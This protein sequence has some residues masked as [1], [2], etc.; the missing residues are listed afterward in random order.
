MGTVPP[1][2]SRCPKAETEYLSPNGRYR[3]PSL[4]ETQEN[5]GKGTLSLLYFQLLWNV[6]KIAVYGPLCN[7]AWLQGGAEMPVTAHC[8]MLP[9]F[10]GYQTVLSLLR[11]PNTTVKP[12]ES[13]NKWK[14]EIQINENFWN[15]NSIGMEGG[16]CTTVDNVFRNAV[17][18][19]KILRSSCFSSLGVR[20]ENIRK[21]PLKD[22][23]EKAKSRGF[24][25]AHYK[26]QGGRWF[27]RVTN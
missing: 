8:V 12:V 26:V 16:D 10:C 7:F 22:K 25:G 6:S 23:N 21:S 5:G 27:L 20:K 17:L 24:H 18:S 9:I 15:K 13:K 1:Y 3:I 4:V 2:F 19:W 11:V 14:N